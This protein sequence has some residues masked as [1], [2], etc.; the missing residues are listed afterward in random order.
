MSHHARLI[1]VFLIEM[2]F[3]H[4][5]QAGLELLS[6]NDPPTLAPKSGGITGVSHHTQ[7]RSWS[8]VAR[9][10]LIATSTSRV[11]ASL[12]PQPPAELELQAWHAPPHLTNFFVFLVE[13]PCWPGWSRTPD[14]RLLLSLWALGGRSG[15]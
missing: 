1:F 5:A 12:L 4:V 8:A 3:C 11:R 13:M 7:P 6:S 14:L 15:A 10:Q 2:E 9:S